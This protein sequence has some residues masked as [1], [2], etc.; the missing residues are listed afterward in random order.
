VKPKPGDVPETGLS[1][2]ERVISVWQANALPFIDWTRGLRS[3]ARVG[4]G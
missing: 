2:G 1:S 4:S 3:R